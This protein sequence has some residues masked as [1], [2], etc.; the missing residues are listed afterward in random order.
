MTADSSPGPDNAESS[1]ELCA[2]PSVSDWNEF[3]SGA[4]ET[5]L[6]HRADWGRPL[7][8]YGLRLETLTVRAKQRLVGVLPL[9][10]QRSLLFGRRLV[11][12]PW[13]DASGILTADERARTLLLEGAL[14]LAS[15]LGCDE[16]L[17]RQPEAIP[18]WQVERDDKIAMQLLLDSDP[19]RL[20]KRFDPKVRN[21]VRKAEKS[22]VSTETL[23]GTETAGF[24]D[25]YSANM[26][27][28]GSPSHSLR[29]FREVAATFPQETQVH[30]ARFDG[31]VIGAGLTLRNGIRLDIPWASS[32]QQY[33]RL[34]VNHALYWHILRHACLSGLKSFY[35]GRSTRDSGQHHFKKQWG[36]DEAPLFWYR[37]NC[38]GEQQVDSSSPQ[39]AFGLAV[40]LWRRLPLTLTRWM[41]P[42]IISKVA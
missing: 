8:A 12:L 11:S 3:V 42:R 29:F 39:E 41:G 9:V 32:L 13:I 38:R 34:C 1:L 33:N 20:W 18:G 31:Q 35:F 4:T 16:V 28:L 21:Q 23:P 17:L 27:D 25:V 6:W 36:A 30:V 22:G 14:A 40:R 24:F 2:K 7:A 26:R 15:K 10:S 5:P 19:E 37:L